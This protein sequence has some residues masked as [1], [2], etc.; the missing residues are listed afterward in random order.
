MNLADEQHGHQD[1][2]YDND[3]PHGGD[4]FL[5]GVVRVDGSIALGLGDVLAFQKLDKIVAKPHRNDECDDD[6]CC[7]A[8]GDVVEHASAWKIVLVKIVEKIV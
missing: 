7:G 3:A 4:T 1:G 2:C 8:K 6:G 5:F